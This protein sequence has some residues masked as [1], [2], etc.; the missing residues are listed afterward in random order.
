MKI[1]AKPASIMGEYIAL[2]FLVPHNELRGFHH[3][4]PR[5]EIW[6]RQDVYDN[7][8]RYPWIRLHET[9]EIDLM[10]NYKMPYKEAHR[11][12]EIVDGLW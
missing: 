1:K 2:H 8:P 7:L 11:R 4:I 12:A 3:R 9:Y 6:I 5:N 10:K